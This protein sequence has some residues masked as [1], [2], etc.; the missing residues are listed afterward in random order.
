MNAEVAILAGGFGSRLKSILGDDVPKPMAIIEGK[1]L[2]EHQLNLCRV[3]GFTDI[4]VLLHHL[5][6]V[7]K[8]YFGSGDDWGVNIKYVVEEHPRGTAGAIHDALPMLSKQFLVIYGDTFLDVDLRAFWE[9]KLASDDLLTFAHPN[10]HPYDSDL[11]VLDEQN[12]VLDV[13]RPDF[14][15][16]L[17]YNNIVNAALYVAERSAFETL[18]P[19][20]G[21]MDIAS[22]LF[23]A[24]IA[25]GLSVRAYRS[26]EYIRDM[27]TPA[28][29]ERVTSDIRQGIPER[30]A[31]RSRRRCVFLDRDGVINHD[32]G[33][34]NDKVDFRLKDNVGQAIKNLNEA[35]W[36]VICV[37]NQPVVAR[38]ELTT[39]G[40][41][42]IHK[43][44]EVLLGRE[45][46]YLDD[47]YHCPHH[48]DKGFHGEVEHLKIQCQC[49]K[50]RPGMLLQA[51][52]AYNIDL[53]GSWM[54]GDHIRDIE[55]GSAAGV[56]TILLGSSKRS[57]AEDIAADFTTS[58]LYSAVELIIQN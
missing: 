23:V 35:G 7:I 5:P 14:N 17:T 28:R 38:G 33:H 1:P 39:D 9:S 10:S 48:P 53:E 22:E 31:S 43:Y 13:F 11:L 47:L 46:A 8:E 15:Q 6:N 2:L 54:V 40:L 25:E 51:A 34:L 49:R 16:T 3:H 58:T 19:C 57:R 27:G 42:E 52:K 21:Q 20:E 12:Y 37:T 55:A 45:G 4:V 24:M 44:M 29:Y 30:L 56:K 50:P 41:A 26:V 36:L 18:V 32:I